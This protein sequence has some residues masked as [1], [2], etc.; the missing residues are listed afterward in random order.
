MRATVSERDDNPETNLHEATNLANPPMMEPKICRSLLPTP[1]RWH[2]PQRAHN[3]I[4]AGCRIEISTS[5]RSIS[6]ERRCILPTCPRCHFGSVRTDPSAA[7]NR[8]CANV[9][10][11]QHEKL[12]SSISPF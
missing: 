7:P 1:A 11:A 2:D 5:F 10:A 9:F 12:V 3:E 8:Q 6:C 4:G